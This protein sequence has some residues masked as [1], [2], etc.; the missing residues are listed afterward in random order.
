MA[1]EPIEKKVRSRKKKSESKESVTSESAEPKAKRAPKAVPVPLFQA[2]PPTKSTPRT[3][4][5]RKSAPVATEVDGDDLSDKGGRRRRRRR[6]GR[7]RHR[8][9]E[10]ATTES[11]E[12]AAE[13][14]E[15]GEIKV[16]K[17]RKRVRPGQ[18]N[19]TA[20][21]VVDEDGVVTVVKV[22]E[23]RP[24]RSAPARVRE[25]RDDYRRDRRGPRTSRVL[26][27]PTANPI[28]TPIAILTAILIEKIVV[29][30][31]SSPKVNSLREGNQLNE[32]C[33]SVKRVI[34]LR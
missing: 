22:R 13:K 26:G 7:G 27:T 33:W 21:E 34:A 30:A 10:T 3:S 1:N 20:G 17:R 4:S 23:E 15:A 6:G 8:D 12:A 29:E 11:S 5:A 25:K 18:E 2:P 28:A 14:H 9:A 32:R 16:R 24:T 31:S 19:V